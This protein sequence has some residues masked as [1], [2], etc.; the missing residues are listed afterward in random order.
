MY[1][2][3]YIGWRMRVY[4]CLYMYMCMSMGRTFSCFSLLLMYGYITA[5]LM[6][7]TISLVIGSAMVVCGQYPS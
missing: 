5:F 4:G 7:F 2:Y 3:I 6:L 1:M